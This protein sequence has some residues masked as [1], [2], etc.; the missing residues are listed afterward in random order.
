MTENRLGRV[1][2]EHL[3][4]RTQEWL[5]Q[6]V[7]MRQATISRII[8]GQ[9]APTSDTVRRIA[10]ALG[11]DE[12]YLLRLS[13]HTTTPPPNERDPLV[14]GLSHRLHSYPPDRRRVLL[15]MITA[16]LDGADEL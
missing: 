5:A 10:K 14:E 9:Q 7:D 11:L 8:R 12:V 13:G 6:Q 3:G 4:E 15:A 16:M 2:Q 1:I